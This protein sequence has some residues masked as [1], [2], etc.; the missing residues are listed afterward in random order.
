[1]TVPRYDDMLTCD[2]SERLRS[3]EAFRCAWRSHAGRRVGG[4]PVARESWAHAVQTMAAMAY[5]SDAL[6]QVARHVLSGGLPLYQTGGELCAA[7]WRGA[8]EALGQPYHDVIL[9]A[10]PEPGRPSDQKRDWTLRE[11]VLVY[12][13]CQIACAP[14]SATAPGYGWAL[15]EAATAAGVT[16]PPWEPRA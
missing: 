1:M 5:R 6:A 9:R 14:E 13:Y 3:R 4:P 16:L 15:E 11:L 2:Y 8:F 7:I 10:S 12:A